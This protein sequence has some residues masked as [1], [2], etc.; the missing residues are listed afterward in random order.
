MGPAGAYDVLLIARAHEGDAAV[1]FHWETPEDGT[2][3][4]P[5]A[6]LAIASEFAPL[7]HTFPDLTV[8]D[9]RDDPAHARVR[10]TIISADEVT[11]TLESE[12]TPTGCPAGSLRFFADHTD[13]PQLQDADPPHRY[14]VELELDGER[15]EAVAEWPADQMSEGQP[16]VRLEFTPAL[17]SLQ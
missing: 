2:I 11:Q 3:P 16:Y 4:Q 12:A 14:H 8:T 6:A 1:M 15:Y 7:S 5:Q 17:P 10:I 9:L 13:S